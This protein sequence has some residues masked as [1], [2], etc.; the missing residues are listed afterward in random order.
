MWLN[1]ADAVISEFEPKNPWPHQ[2]ELIGREMPHAQSW[3]RVLQRAR[4]EGGIDIKDDCRLTDSSAR[5]H[6]D[7]DNWRKR[8]AVPI[9][10]LA[11]NVSSKASGRSLDYLEMSA[12]EKGFVDGA[13]RDDLL[14]FSVSQHEM[15]HGAAQT[16]SAYVQGISEV[17]HC[18]SA[19]SGP[20]L[21]RIVTVWVLPEGHPLCQL[22]AVQRL[23]RVGVEVHAIEQK[24]MLRA[25]SA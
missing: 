14:V 2:R 1:K 12:I 18:S 19:G 4:E 8:G 7:G 15:W 6:Q 25:T 9:I 16:T 13:E 23:Q 21:K 22:T 24:H 10:R 20:C 5:C 3:I 17:C 11:I